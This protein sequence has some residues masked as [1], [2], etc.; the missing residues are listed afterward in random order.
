MPSLAAGPRVIALLVALPASIAASANSVE[1]EALRRQAADA[2]RRGD[3]AKACPLFRA[4]LIDAVRKDAPEPTLASLWSDQ[5]LCLLRAGDVQGSVAASWRAVAHAQGKVLQGALV[6]LV[7]AGEGQPDPFLLPTRRCVRLDP[8]SDV[9]GEKPPPPR[10]LC[11]VPPKGKSLPPRLDAGA[12]V[13]RPANGR[14]T[15][16]VASGTPDFPASCA[17]LPARFDDAPCDWLECRL[18]LLGVD[19][20]TEAERETLALLRAGKATG[21]VRFAREQCDVHLARAV[22]AFGAS[23]PSW[24]RLD[25]GAPSCAVVDERGLDGLRRC[26]RRKADGGV[27]GW[28]ESCRGGCFDAAGEPPGDEASVESSSQRLSDGGLHLRSCRPVV[29]TLDQ[30]LVVCADASGPTAARFLG[31]PAAL[32]PWRDADQRRGLENGEALKSGGDLVRW[33]I[34]RPEPRPPVGEPCP[35]LRP[36]AAQPKSD[37]KAF[38]ELARCLVPSDTAGARHAIGDAVVRGDAATRLAAY[39]RL[40]ELGATVEGKAEGEN[41]ESFP[42]S[43]PACTKRFRRCTR[44]EATD[45]GEDPSVGET[46]AFTD[47]YSRKGDL[48]PPRARPLRRVLGSV[49]L[50]GN[51]RA[52]DFSTP[53][54]RA[55]DLDSPW[56]RPASHTY[57]CE[58]SE[59]CDVVWSDPC[60]GRVGLWCSFSGEDG[61]T[62]G[63]DDKPWAEELVLDQP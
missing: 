12:L 14:W 17:Q 11:A 4:A 41:C 46:I 51:A 40:A 61:C 63:S 26:E 48:R 45:A 23:S 3:F 43:V 7:L 36:A 8:P 42:S 59:T 56:A 25:A 34:E 52:E 49:T 22:A 53:D 1:H 21:S 30:R 19:A 28:Y 37:A 58:L 35:A 62:K 16:E 18:E 55:L 57:S 47:L 32:S 39:G 54:Q 27:V 50:G 60:G 2:F 33:S 10:F 20:W 38:F 24:P 5:G 31:A 9:E 44:G 29:E 15:L 6:N 13:S